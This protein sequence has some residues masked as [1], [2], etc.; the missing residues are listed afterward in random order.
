MATPEKHPIVPETLLRPQEIKRESLIA[1]IRVAET[2]NL[3]IPWW[4]KYGQPAFDRLVAVFEGP[5]DKAGAVVEQVLE[6]KGIAPQIRVFPRG[7]PAVTA[8]RVE[9]DASGAA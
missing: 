7:I 5:A 9:I 6:V 8:V 4:E 3:D 2:L 1:L